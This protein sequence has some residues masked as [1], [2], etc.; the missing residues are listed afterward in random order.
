MD[1]VISSAGTILFILHF[2]GIGKQNVIFG[3][4]PEFLPYQPNLFD[5]SSIQNHE[6]EVSPFL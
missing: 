1:R 4:L 6:K 5:S 3:A 2:A